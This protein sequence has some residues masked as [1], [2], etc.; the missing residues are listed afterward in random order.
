MS[1]LSVAGILVYLYLGI[2]KYASDTQWL[3]LTSVGALAAIS[4]SVFLAYGIISLIQN[5]G[6]IGVYQCFSCVDAN[7]TSATGN[8]DSTHRCA[9][10]GWK[11]I[12]TLSQCEPAVAKGIDCQVS[13]LCINSA[14]NTFWYSLVSTGMYAVVLLLTA[15]TIFT[16]L[17]P[18]LLLQSS[19]R[20]QLI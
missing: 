9:T 14:K 1:L 15:A 11:L 4:L 13:D 19:E 18:T 6:I 5:S 17:I 8:C 20:S 3:V 2:V 16:K 7:G 12:F 10:D